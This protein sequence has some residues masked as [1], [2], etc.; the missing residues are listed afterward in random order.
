MYITTMHLQL[1]FLIGFLEVII[2]NQVMSW[3]E[4]LKHLYIFFCFVNSL[5][6]YLFTKMNVVMDYQIH[7]CFHS[8]FIVTSLID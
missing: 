7:V 1:L 5:I 8:I 2:Y 3:I 6:N 4:V